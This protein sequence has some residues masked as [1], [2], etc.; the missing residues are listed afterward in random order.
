MSRRLSVHRTA[1]TSKR[2]FRITGLEWTQFD[3]VVCE[4][5]QGGVIGRGEALGVYYLDETVASME[6]QIESIGDRICAGVS[7]DELQSLLPAGGA[8]NAVDCALWDLEAQQKKT[9]VWALA[10]V[11]ADTV[12]TVYTIGLEDDPAEMA[13]KAAAA[14]PLTL[15]KVKLNG[16]RPVERID[17]I[18][19]ARPDARIVVDANQGFTFDQLRE[20]APK[21]GQLGVLM[22]E[23]PLK[24]GG[25]AELEGYRSP[26]PLCGDESCLHRGELEAATRRYQMINIKLDKTGG[27]TE[28]L[29]LAK[30]ARERGLGLMVG[31]MGGSSL[32]MA[33]SHVVA[34]LC[35]FVDIDGPLLQKWDHLD[36]LRYEQGKVSVGSRPFWGNAGTR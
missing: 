15:L 33:P 22:I 5:E 16:D 26:V 13:A 30:A 28:A 36:G 31:C 6:A 8:R 4:I 29:L 3:S 7:R 27:L 17:A 23:Q 32:A 2:P 12:E 14:K 20:V 19:K 1:W 9:S 34:Q 24:R 10:G 21:L 35:K 18:R 11:K 25:D